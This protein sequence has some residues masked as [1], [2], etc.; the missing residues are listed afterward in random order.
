MPDKELHDT[1][2]DQNNKNNFEKMTSGP[3]KWFV[4]ITFIIFSTSLAM[5]EI[6][7]APVPKQTAAYYGIKGK[8]SEISRENIGSV[9]LKLNFKCIKLCITDCIKR[10]TRNAI[11]KNY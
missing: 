10:V 3:F 2:S 1:K 11:L 5:S 7:F 9:V 4:L 6:I 8:Y